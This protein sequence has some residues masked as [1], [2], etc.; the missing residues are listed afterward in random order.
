MGRNLSL[1]EALAELAPCRTEDEIVAWAAK[2]RGR[3]SAEMYAAN[4]VARHRY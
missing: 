2:H 3:G 4:I 1:K